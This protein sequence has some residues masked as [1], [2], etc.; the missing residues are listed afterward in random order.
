MLQKY[1]FFHLF[2]NNLVIFDISQTV[3]N[4][5]N[6]YICVFLYLCSLKHIYHL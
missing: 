4:T 1:I 5:L 2:P 6:T 3:Y